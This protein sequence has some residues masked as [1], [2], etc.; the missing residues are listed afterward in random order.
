MLKVIIVGYD[1]MLA[2]L[3]I[4]TL[5][6]GHKVVGVLRN[7]RVKYTKFSLF[8][9]DIF[10]P[11]RDFS[12]VKSYKIHDIKAD[13]V[14][15]KA[16]LKDVRKLA[17]DVILVG[18]WGEKLSQDVIESV[19]YC[20]NVH[21]SLLPKHRGANPY[22]WTLH[23]GD[24]KTGVTFHL[25]DSGYDTGDI[26]FQAGF[27]IDSD[28]NALKLKGKCCKLA[29]A[30]VQDVLN[31]LENGEIIPVKQNEKEASFEK[32]MDAGN[33]I[34]DLTR[35]KLEIKNHIRAISPYFKPIFKMNGECFK[36]IHHKIL[37]ENEFLLNFK[38]GDIIKREK[39][40]IL[41]KCKDGA[42]AFEI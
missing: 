11:S 41:M 6:A 17:P 25:V 40:Q 37:D 8:L 22:F 20:I 42:I 2:N 1:K 30:M 19:K 10:A 38:A 15:S 36:A 21:P 5:S 34:L 26:L 33:L 24:E 7:D 18:S 35:T 4:G 14:N 39:N 28:I 27:S 31:G 32:Q 9:K 3:I 29:Q 23:N 13:S 16:F 12:F